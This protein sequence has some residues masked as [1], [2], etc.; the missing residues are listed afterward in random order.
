MTTRCPAA[1]VATTPERDA[2]L[3]LLCADEELVRAEFEAIVAAEWPRPPSRRAVVHG[4]HGGSG[5]P[6][7]GRTSPRMPGPVPEHEPR[8]DG[9]GRQRSPPGARPSTD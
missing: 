9:S 3:D 8:I 4:L 6:A 1:H 7:P 5:G 2:F